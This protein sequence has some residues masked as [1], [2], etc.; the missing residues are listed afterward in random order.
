M[1]YNLRRGVLIMD[2]LDFLY[3][4]ADK[5]FTGRYYERLPENI[6]FATSV[7]DLYNMDCGDDFDYEIINPNERHYK[8]LLGNLIESDSATLTI[9]SN[10][11][12]GYRIGAHIL[13]Q[14]N[15]L[16]MITSITDDLS[17]AS[18]EAARVLPIPPATEWVIRL[19]EVD[20]PRE[21][22]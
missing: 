19:I 7:E 17:A 16:C 2:L 20:N 14:D 21:L 3:G 12:L 18:K 5:T 4:K 11:D 9:K 13:T 10:E 1:P 8:N 6:S 15:L 22:M